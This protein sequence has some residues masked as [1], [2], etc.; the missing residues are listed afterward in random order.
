MRLLPT[1]VIFSIWVSKSFQLVD[2]YNE[3]CQANTDP[4]DP[5]INVGFPLKSYDGAL[6]HSVTYCDFDRWGAGGRLQKIPKGI[7]N[8]PN[9]ILRLRDQRVQLNKSM[10][11][12]NLTMCVRLY[13]DGNYIND[14]FNKSFQYMASL[15]ELFCI[16]MT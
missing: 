16:L 5:R 15:K 2:M 14:I 13:L 8:Y 6:N 1:L 10:P 4:K 9:L 7:K 12:R 11:L 3:N